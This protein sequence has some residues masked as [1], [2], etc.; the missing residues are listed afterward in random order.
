MQDED[1][2]IIE[3]FNNGDSE[4]VTKL[5][6]KYKHRVLNFSMRIL[7]S[8]AD[9]EDVT[10]EVFLTLLSGKYR[11]DSNA[12]FT[13]WMYT[14]ARNSCISRIR[15]RKKLSSLSTNNKNG[16]GFEREIKDAN[17]NSR[18]ALEKKEAGQHVKDA[19]YALPANQKEAI[20]LREYQKCSYQ[21]IAEICDCSLEQ[22]KILIFRAR[23][24]LRV[25][26][27][28]FLNEEEN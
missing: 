28:S 20:I 24:S 18:E 19:I 15:K 22:V 5:F 23:E 12:K 2:Q 9:A 17:D 26:L 13:T 10:G 8:R 3:A 21:E 1:K 14:V 16:E 7:G 27:S 6:E 11:V 4:I 25:Q